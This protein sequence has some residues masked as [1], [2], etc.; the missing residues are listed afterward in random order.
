M[1]GGR[2]RAGPRY[3]RNVTS[4]RAVIVEAE[5][6]TIGCADAMDHAGFEIGHEDLLVGAVERHVAERRAGVLA[7]VERDLRE[8]RGR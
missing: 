6:G 5:I 2:L 1:I 4:L 3:I 8:R 7:V